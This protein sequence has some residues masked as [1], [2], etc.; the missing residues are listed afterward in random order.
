MN[1]VGHQEESK[2]I[3]ERLF[4]AMLFSIWCHN[5]F[6]VRDRRQISLQLLGE[7]KRININFY[8]P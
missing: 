5:I 4:F 7:F 2:K 8:S 1:Q 3:I 6:L